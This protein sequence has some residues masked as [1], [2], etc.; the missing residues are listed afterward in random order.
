MT[1]RKPRSRVDDF[2]ETLA[3]SLRV[4]TIMKDCDPEH[5]EFYRG[6]VAAIEMLTQIYQQWKALCEKKHVK[7][8]NKT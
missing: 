6:E 2:E 1:R 3:L 4:A 8:T 7:K 5:L